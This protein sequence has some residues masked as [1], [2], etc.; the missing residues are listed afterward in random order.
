MTGRASAGYAESPAGPRRRNLLSRIL[1]ALSLA[2]LVAAL[3][4][5]T[6]TVFVRTS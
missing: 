6:L 4:A 1:L 3:R 2:T 5:R